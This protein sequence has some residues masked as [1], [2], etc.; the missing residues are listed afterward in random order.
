[1][2]TLFHVSSPIYGGS[3]ADRYALSSQVLHHLSISTAVWGGGQPLWDL[4]IPELVFLFDSRLSYYTFYRLPLTGQANI[5]VDQMKLPK[6]H[7][8]DH[9]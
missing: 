6:A 5:E 4:I 8:Y 9:V 1:M 3:Q 2:R 7:R